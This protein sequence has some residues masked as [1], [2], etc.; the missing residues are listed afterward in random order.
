[1]KN[2]ITSVGENPQKYLNPTINLTFG[3]LDNP[4]I[5]AWVDYDSSPQK[6]VFNTK[7]V[8][9]D[10]QIKQQFDEQQIFRQIC[11]FG[12]TLILSQALYKCP[13][14]FGYGQNGKINW[15]YEYEKRN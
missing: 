7:H 5:I 4:G 3:E 9:I 6:L 11:K 15:N 14:L 10:D 1:V 12:D 13:Y 8:V 2:I